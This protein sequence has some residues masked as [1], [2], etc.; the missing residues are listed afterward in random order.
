M[1]DAT[2]AQLSLEH[3]IP[4]LH[5]E[6]VIQDSALHRTQA[7]CELEKTLKENYVSLAQDTQ[8]EYDLAKQSIRVIASSGPILR[9]DDTQLCLY[10]Y[11][12]HAPDEVYFLD[13]EEQPLA[14][15]LKLPAA[16]LGT[17]CCTM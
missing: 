17:R 6:A 4:R 8:L 15:C 13:F 3:A 11:Q 7:A 14:R 10:I 5:I 16:S 9:L 2:E 1:T 12:L